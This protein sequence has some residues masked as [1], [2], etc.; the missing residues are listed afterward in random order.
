M[1]R[2]VGRFVVLVAGVTLIRAF[3]SAPWWLDVLGIVSGIALIWLTNR[4]E[5]MERLP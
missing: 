4:D 1:M 5:F 2:R 3:E